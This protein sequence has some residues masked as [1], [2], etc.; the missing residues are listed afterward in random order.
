MTLISGMMT[1]VSF[2]ITA[3]PM[4]PSLGVLSYSVRGE[5]VDSMENLHL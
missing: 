3:F 1:Y 2:Y 4:G 5:E